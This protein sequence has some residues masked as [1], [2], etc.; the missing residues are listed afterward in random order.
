MHEGGPQFETK[1]NLQKNYCVK[2]TTVKEIQNLTKSLEDQ[3]ILLVCLQG[4]YIS[5]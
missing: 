4:S 5:K 3:I 2:S 1:E